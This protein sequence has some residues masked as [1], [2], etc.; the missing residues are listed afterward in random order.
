M[1]IQVDEM[2][3]DGAEAIAYK[4]I[5]HKREIGVI[6][7]L[8]QP[9]SNYYRLDQFRVKEKVRNR[10]LG[11][12]LLT[13]MIEE[14]RRAGGTSLIVYPNSEPY[15]GDTEVE[16]EKLYKI[17]EHLGFALEDPQADRSRPNNKMIMMI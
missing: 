14:I 17:Y 16:S 6:T 9:D 15:P 13:K 3:N 7:M 1:K 2:I 4:G 12:K 8:A 11:R 10:G 5:F